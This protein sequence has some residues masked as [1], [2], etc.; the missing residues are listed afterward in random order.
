MGQWRMHGTSSGNV[1]LVAQG[2]HGPIYGQA[3]R[4]TG[5]VKFALAGTNVN[6]NTAQRAGER[7]AGA[8]AE[9]RAG[10]LKESYKNAQSAVKSS[11]QSDDASQQ[12]NAGIK[13]GSWLRSIWRLVSRGDLRRAAHATNANTEVYAAAIANQVA[14]YIRN[15]GIRYG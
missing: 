9:N 5:E 8:I 1:G 7:L 14:Q 10:E 6:V 15:L 4:G 2:P 11:R 3:N 12:L 13:S